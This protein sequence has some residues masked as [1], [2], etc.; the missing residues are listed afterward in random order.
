MRIK[1]AAQERCKMEISIGGVVR[2]EDF[3]NQEKLMD[4]LRDVLKRSSVLL[5]AP[6]RAG[7]TSV[8]QKLLDEQDLY[9]GFSIKYY[10]CHTLGE[11]QTVYSEIQVCAAAHLSD[12]ED[13]ILIIILDE[14]SS[15]IDYM[16][17]DQQKNEV[18]R[19]LR[20]FKGL[21]DNPVYNT[22]V[23]FIIGGS[24]SIDMVL[25]SINASDLIGDFYRLPVEPFDAETMKMYLEAILPPKHIDLEPN[26][27][28]LII[29][30][31]QKSYPYFINLLI[32]ALKH[33][34]IGKISKADVIRTYREHVIT[35]EGANH[36]SYFYER[37]QKYGL[38][39]KSHI[40]ATR[41]ILATIAA[42]GELDENDA[43]DLFQKYTRSHDKA[44][45]DNLMADLENEFYVARRYGSIKY[46]FAIDV[47]REWWKRWHPPED[48][49]YIS[50]AFITMK[51]D[52]SHIYYKIHGNSIL[53]KDPELISSM[54]TALLMYT[55]DIGFTTPLKK[56]EFEGESWLISTGDA[57]VLSCKVIGRGSTRKIEEKMKNVVHDVEIEYAESLDKWDGNVNTFSDIG[58]NIDTLFRW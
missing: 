23:R 56:V 48:K 47:M 45:F 16:L 9:P 18:I 50:E 49:A 22:K 19:V 34:Y 14:F 30:L 21:R 10:N 13:K 3:F 58:K 28:E 43:F 24:T 33:R 38:V 1:K 54:Q 4:T 40:R 41:E 57:L 17:R 5:V 52:G 15:I 55:R 6:R 53:S 35:G 7:K 25:R 46:Y 8:M 2:G 11:L 36:F 26:A 44:C 12:T 31:F 51:K 37:V 32:A 29:Q 42:I 39:K 20:L 27:N